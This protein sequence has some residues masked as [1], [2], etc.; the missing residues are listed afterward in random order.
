MRKLQLPF[1]LKETHDQLTGENWYD[2]IRNVSTTC[3][4]NILRVM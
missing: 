3:I 1:R 2:G 4:W